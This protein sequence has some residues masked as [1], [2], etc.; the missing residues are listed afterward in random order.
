MDRSTI[1]KEW[2]AILENGLEDTVDLRPLFNNLF[3]GPA[4]ELFFQITTA[5]ASHPFY[6]KFVRPFSQRIVTICMEELPRQPKNAILISK[7][8][9]SA[10]L[11]I[12]S[13]QTVADNYVTVTNKLTDKALSIF[14]SDNIAVEKSESV[15][16]YTSLSTALSRMLVAP[17]PSALVAH[18]Q[19]LFKLPFMRHI[20]EMCIVVLKSSKKA[21]FTPTLELLTAFCIRY[22]TFA[23]LNF[24]DLM[25]CAVELQ[26]QSSRAQMIALNEFISVL[27]KEHGLHGFRSSPLFGQFLYNTARFAGCLAT[28]EYIDI[29]QALISHDSNPDVIYSDPKVQIS[30]LN[31]I[32][33][34]VE[35]SIYVLPIDFVDW[36][37]RHL[38]AQLYAL[39]PGYTNLTPGS[40]MPHYPPLTTATVNIIKAVQQHHKE[41]QKRKAVATRKIN[42]GKPVHEV[43][44]ISVKPCS[45]ELA[46]SFPSVIEYM[47]YVREAIIEL[48]VSIIETSSNPLTSALIPH[49]NTVCSKL[50][51]PASKMFKK[52]VD[53]L[54]RPVSMGI[55]ERRNLSTADPLKQIIVEKPVIIETSTLATATD[56]PSIK[57]TPPTPPPEPTFSIKPQTNTFKKQSIK[58]QILDAFKEEQ[59]QKPATESL[60]NQ[61]AILGSPPDTAVHSEEDEELDLDF[62]I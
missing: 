15:I 52:H 6:H 31:L 13:T 18:D 42:P 4:E 9:S 16:S 7:A 57:M 44:H 55:Y 17:V 56:E 27:I 32:Q 47:P 38:T 33:V 49:L 21:Y 51:T 24:V 3:S 28:D 26:G 45:T 2:S 41:F 14:E 62:Q 36:I 39:S 22:H 10:I 58:L 19:S 43:S 50:N 23:A 1:Y 29:S 11:C 40:I 8:L 5:L 12:G 59:V 30:S 37:S 48:L 53:L 54:A 25:T 60:T 46:L 34:L 61:Q 35:E 20:Y